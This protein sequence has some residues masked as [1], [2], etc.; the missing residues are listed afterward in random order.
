MEDKEP[1]DSWI[2]RIRWSRSGHFK[3]D[4]RVNAIASL[5]VEGAITSIE[6]PKEVREAL[7]VGMRYAGADRTQ[8]DAQFEDYVKAARVA[9]QWISLLDAMDF[10]R[11]QRWTTP[12]LRQRALD[13]LSD[14]LDAS[15]SRDTREPA[16]PAA[17]W[18][19]SI[20][21]APSG[22]QAGDEQLQRATDAWLSGTTDAKTFVDQVVELVD[23]S[24]RRKHGTQPGNSEDQI[25]AWVEDVR[26]VA[27]A[28]VWRTV[29]DYCDK[30][31]LTSPAQRRHA[32]D[33]MDCALDTTPPHRDGPAV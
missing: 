6:V 22:W 5:W 1:G 13:M 32:L 11:Q 3:E 10:A 2:K 28:M 4:E 30:Q 27:K 15:A 7:Q 20:R 23:A 26:L 18:W 31:G 33:M 8:P 12:E 21:S 14:E 17:V 25:S 24:V 9:A 29:A 16:P 19:Q